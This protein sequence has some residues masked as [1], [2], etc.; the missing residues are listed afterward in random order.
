MVDI[1]RSDVRREV[2]ELER[3]V[4]KAESAET[5]ANTARA[6]LDLKTLM[7]LSP[8]SSLYDLG[9][10]ERVVGNQ[11]LGALFSSRLER[12]LGILGDIIVDNDL[13][14]TYTSLIENW[15]TFKKDLVERAPSYAQE[16]QS[17]L[18]K[19]VTSGS[20]SRQFIVQYENT[21]RVLR[22]KG[23][24]LV[25]VRMP[26]GEGMMREA[27]PSEVFY[28]AVVQNMVTLLQQGKFN[29]KETRH[30]DQLILDYKQVRD[31]FE[32]ITGKISTTSYKGNTLLADELFYASVVHQLQRHSSALESTDLKKAEELKR[33]CEDLAGKGQDHFYSRMEEEGDAL[34][35]ERF[36]VYAG[37]F[38]RFSRNFLDILEETEDGVR[39]VV[40]GLRTRFFG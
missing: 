31:R 13:E 10:M 37:A 23:I 2:D 35:R 39:C 20:F 1:F 40:E 34:R 28:G 21:E 36:E 32:E 9:V 8:H 5:H 33:Y 18:L 24:E 19:M 27:S 4:A 11:L 29:L 16:L 26:A 6:L 12:E 17:H 14:R 30:C 3:L 22:E 38:T 7:R 25:T 15:D